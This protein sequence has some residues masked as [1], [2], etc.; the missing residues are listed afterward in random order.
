MLGN[1]I[2]QVLSVSS[3]GRCGPPVEETSRLVDFYKGVNNISPLPVG[4]VRPPYSHL[5]RSYVQIV[6]YIC[7]S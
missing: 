3:N 4:Q 5:N 7:H 2:T 1:C 6:G